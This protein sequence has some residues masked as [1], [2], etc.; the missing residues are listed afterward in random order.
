MLVEDVD[1][2]S[3]DDLPEDGQFVVAVSKTAAANPADNV[4][5]QDN[6]ALTT[7]LGHG[8]CMVWGSAQRSDRS[9]LG[10]QRVPVIRKGGG[11]FK[12][13]CFIHDSGAGGTDLPS[14]KYVEGAPLTVIRPE[15]ALQGS[16]ERLLLAPA[17]SASGNNC[18]VVGYCIRVITD[19]AVSGTA[20]VEFYLYDQPRLVVK[21]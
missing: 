18:W 15:S 9:A 2:S 10:D 20:E 12:T 16:Q 8:L 19:S 4:L 17:A 5:S 1:C 7:E 13:K 3:L 6:A 14:V 11:R 21:A